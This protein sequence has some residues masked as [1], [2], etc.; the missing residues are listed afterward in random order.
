MDAYKKYWW[1]AGLLLA[2]AV[3]LFSPLASPHPDGLER[4]AEDKGFLDQARDAPY[5]TIP[6]YL[7]PGVEN[8]ATATI[9]AGVVGT[10]IMFG[11][12][13]GLAWML[14]RRSGNLTQD[15]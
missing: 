14:R 13:C 2:L 8:E 12:G 7:F 6:D 5:K 3:V 1:V 9:L 10:V 11:L 15:A 4:V